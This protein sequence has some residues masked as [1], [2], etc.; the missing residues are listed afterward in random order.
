MKFS[1]F[2]YTRPEY[3]VIKSKIIDTV[4]C[5]DTSKSYIDQKLH[6][7]G[8]NRL[9]NNIE[10][11]STIVSIRYSLNT[12]D[13]FYIEEKQYWDEYSPMY[14]EL[15]SMFYKSIV[16]SKYIDK[17][18]VDYGKQF[19]KICDYSLKAF[20]S[21][22]IPEL[23][24]ENKLCSKYTKLL[25]SAEIEFDGQIKNL[26]GITSY[27]YSKDRK[28]R[29]SASKK[30]YNYF[31]EN[32]DEFGNL[33]DDLVKVRDKMA[34][35]LG[36]DNFVE[37]GYLR[38]MRTEYNEK[39]VKIFRD[40]I[41]NDIVPLANSLYE[42]Q[43]SRLNLEKLDYI[44]ENIEFTNGNAKPR[45]DADY[46]FSSAKK[47]YKGLSD[48]TNEFFNYIIENELIDY[49][50]RANKGAGGYCTYI[51]NH[52]APFI[53]ANF[54]STLDDIDVLT[55]EA[56]HAFQLYMSRW[57]D[58]PEINFPTLD[59]CEI[60]SMSME[61]IT[62]PWMDM[63]FKEDTEKYK[64]SHLSSAIKFI[65]YGALVDEF[66]HEVYRN[67]D[68]SKEK[69]K[70]IWRTLEK[71]YLPHRDYSACDFLQKGGW[72]Y[73]Q[74]HIFKNP[75]YYIDYALA[76]V[77]ALQMWEKSRDGKSD[78]L[79][80]YKKMCAVGGSKSFVEIIEIGNLNSPFEKN[81]LTKIIN[82]VKFY[83]DAVNEEYF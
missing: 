48:E 25:A 72:W 67:P 14:E 66:Q 58:T 7:E 70:N 60:H 12:S 54:N 80:D 56:G 28:I 68:I 41:L 64:F 74:G 10:S 53:F 71:K 49:E 29:V 69:R 20:S 21:L 76:Q 47:M 73:K 35:K 77:C 9:R 22:I 63:F 42:R 23:Q 15:N 45:G 31:E 82:S 40:Q 32:E 38:M 79:S 11:M 17:I 50:T 46:I 55:H 24:Y 34:K 8:L 33:F 52:K 19:L 51:P 78:Y 62:W 6:I 1:E 2:K 16:N 75:F 30:Y 65:P 5:I 59:S 61:F 44:D 27:M 39:M 13:K 57:I 81:A 26:S 3:K 43:A 37:L 83:L 4:N 18:E 36:F